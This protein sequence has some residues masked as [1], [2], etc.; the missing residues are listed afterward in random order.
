MYPVGMSSARLPRPCSGGT[1]TTRALHFP[2]E[3]DTPRPCPGGPRRPWDPCPPLPPR[4]GSGSSTYW[5]LRWPTGAGK[6]AGSS[7]GPGATSDLSGDAAPFRD[8]GARLTPSSR[9]RR[10]ATP[11]RGT[12]RAGKLHF[13]AQSALYHWLLRGQTAAGARGSLGLALVSPKRTLGATSPS[14]PAD[15]QAWGRARGSGRTRAGRRAG[16]S[17]PRGVGS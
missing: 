8:R 15:L 14:G 13:G 7:A 17:R 1:P 12:Q 3:S 11:K 4:P 9:P 16:G 6:V 2:P 5:P 10:R